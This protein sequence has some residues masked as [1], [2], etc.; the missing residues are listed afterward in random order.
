MIT[1]EQFDILE[2][3]RNPIFGSNLHAVEVYRI[4]VR[5][6]LFNIFTCEGEYESNKICIKEAK[7]KII[8]IFNNKLWDLQNNKQ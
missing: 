8:E 3:E 2:M 1:E 4:S 5:F 7:N 6:L